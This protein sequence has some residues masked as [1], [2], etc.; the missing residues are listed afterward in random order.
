MLAEAAV[1][2][3]G[4]ARYGV[5]IAD[6]GLSQAAGAHAPQVAPGFYQQ[7]AFAHLFGRVGGDHAG[8]GAAVNHD[9]V[10]GGV[11]LLGAKRQAQP[12]KA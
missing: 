5:F 8:G 1:E 7:H 4:E 11:F 9:V 6:V 2:I 3:A 10:F 12:K